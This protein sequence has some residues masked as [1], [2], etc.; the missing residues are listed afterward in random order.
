[1]SAATVSDLHELRGLLVE[2]K[3]ESEQLRAER[4]EVCGG[5]QGQTNE[6]C[7][8]TSSVTSTRQAA[9]SAVPTHVLVC[10]AP[11]SSRAAGA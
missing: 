8:L 10:V 11:S 1:M 2:A 4:D 6:L 7:C 3:A 5:Q 9:V